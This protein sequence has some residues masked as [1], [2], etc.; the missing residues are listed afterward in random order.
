MLRFR[1]FMTLAL[2]MGA[3]GTAAAQG[4]AS[5]ASV[6][7]GADRLYYDGRPAE[8]LAM[9]THHLASATDDV[10]ALWRAA[11]AALAVGWLDPVEPVSIRS[12]MLAEELARQAIRIAPDVTEARY[13]LAAALGRR[14]LIAKTPRAAV[15]LT[16]QVHREATQL[17]AIDAR[18]AGAH[19]VLGQ[20]HAEIMRKPWALRTLG[21]RL[22]GGI[23]FK[24]SWAEAERTL[25]TAIDIEPDMMLHRFE[26]ARVYAAT[27]RPALAR[28]LL[29]TV[30]RMPVVHPMDRLFQQHARSLLASLR[31]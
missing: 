18:H 24:A 14:A 19:S 16:D 11:R 9:L 29:E 27:R 22:A 28:P 4:D 17:L 21:L 12:Y 1:Q 7:D 15:S 8:S 3:T 10:P 26:L 20:L 31:S 2:M 25:Q 6:H 13:V 30:L 5:P 23:D